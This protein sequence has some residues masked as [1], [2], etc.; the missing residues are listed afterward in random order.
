MRTL[1]WTAMCIAFG[2]FLG[3]FEVGG[4]TPF[5]HAKAAVDGKQAPKLSQLKEQAEDAVDG[6][7][8][9]LAEAKEEAAQPTEKHSADDKDAVNKLI[10]G[11]RAKP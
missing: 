6:A 3:T 10:A 7:K 5:Q 11:R 4:K 8:K 1:I 9:K 2:I